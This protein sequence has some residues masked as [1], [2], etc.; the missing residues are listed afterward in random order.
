MIV[1]TVFNV[2]TVTEAAMRV[3]EVLRSMGLHPRWLVVPSLYDGRVRLDVPHTGIERVHQLIRAWLPDTLTVELDVAGSITL[4]FDDGYINITGWIPG[5]DGS[6][7][8]PQFHALFASS[9]F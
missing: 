6:D 3:V 5:S 8:L 9:N 1:P 2:S 7:L 4:R